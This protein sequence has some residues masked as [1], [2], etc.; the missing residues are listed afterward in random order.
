MTFNEPQIET[1]ESKI[2]KIILFFFFGEE[3][4]SY[5]KVILKRKLILYVIMLWASQ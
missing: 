4:I 2:T 1:S 5:P 3:S